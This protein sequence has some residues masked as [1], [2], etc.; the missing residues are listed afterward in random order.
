MP[1][2]LP[3]KLQALVSTWV[4]VL[5]FASMW[6]ICWSTTVFP[7]LPGFPCQ[8]SQWQDK[9]WGL[10]RSK[11]PPLQS[12]APVISHVFWNQYCTRRDRK[13][14]SWKVFHQIYPSR[15]RRRRHHP[16]M[17][18]KVKLCSR[19]GHY[20]TLLKVDRDSF[21]L[22]Q[23]FR[24]KGNFRHVKVKVAGAGRSK[25]S[26]IILSN[27]LQQLKSTPFSPGNCSWTCD[28]VRHREEDAKTMMS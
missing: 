15:R 5:V 25:R 7:A 22:M 4:R 9:R 13:E 24:V 27:L 18:A 14:K 10:T 20:L 8:R 2:G 11:R 28:R 21:V 16:V 12:A 6:P 23:L 1:S 3:H 19:Y 26:D 17:W